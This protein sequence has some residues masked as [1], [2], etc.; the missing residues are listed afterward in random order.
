MDRVIFFQFP[1][2]ILNKSAQSN[3]KT[4]RIATHRNGEWTLPLRALK[5]SAA[6][7]LHPHYSTAWSIYITKSPRTCFFLRIWTPFNTR[8]LGLTGIHTPCISGGWAV[9]AQVWPTHR[10]ATSAVAGR[11]YTCNACDAA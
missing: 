5:H 2:G 7:T 6:V 4:V 1:E 10:R 3:F 8:C 11:I 9:F